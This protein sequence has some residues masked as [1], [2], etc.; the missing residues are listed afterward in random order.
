MTSQIACISFF[1]RHYLLPLI[2]L[3]WSSFQNPL[4]LC[5]TIFLYLCLIRHETFRLWVYSVVSVGRPIG[6][7]WSLACLPLLQ[8]NE[9]IFCL[10]ISSNVQQ[11]L[12]SPYSV[13]PT[14]AQLS[15]NKS[16]YSQQHNLFMV[17]NILIDLIIPN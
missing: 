15:K 16:H 8:K 9:N 7:H 12:K 3:A 2:Y 13:P 14:V 4:V 10:I 1:L 11:P 6:I 5:C 17:I